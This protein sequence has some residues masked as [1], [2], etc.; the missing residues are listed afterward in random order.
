MGLLKSSKQF[1][2]YQAVRK[3]ESIACADLFACS[4]VASISELI[5]IN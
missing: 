2:L 4:L 3:L 5:L 1:W